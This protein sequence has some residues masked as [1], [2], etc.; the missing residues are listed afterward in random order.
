[1]VRLLALISGAGHI[2]LGYP[3]RGMTF[4]VLTGCLAANLFL[5]RGLA[6]D[7]I[8]VRSTVSLFRLGL[9]F[10]AFVAI[11]ALCLR[12]LLARQRAETG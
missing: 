8:A 3:L 6:H 2:L 11:Y 4:L 10:A 12:D 7:P 9:T 5:W 1:M